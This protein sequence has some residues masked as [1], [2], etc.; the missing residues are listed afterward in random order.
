M[1]GQQSQVLF[2]KIL[3]NIFGKT[4]HNAGSLIMI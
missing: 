4:D 2:N 3:M 1:G